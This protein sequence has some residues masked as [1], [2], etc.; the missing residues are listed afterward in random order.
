MPQLDIRPSDKVRISAGPYAGQRAIVEKA[1]HQTVRVRLQDS[2]RSVSVHP[3]AIANYSAAARKAW[4]TMPARSVGR[5]KG[6]ISNRKSITLRIDEA[7]WERFVA[8]ESEGSIQDRS[9]FI[10][11]ALSTKLKEMTTDRG[12]KTHA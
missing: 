7:L 4:K 12:K 10:E 1:T 3:E 5:P 8:M 9:S 2:E 11:D 6:R